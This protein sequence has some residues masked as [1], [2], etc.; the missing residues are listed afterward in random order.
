MTTYRGQLLAWMD[1]VVPYGSDERLSAQA[2][3]QLAA[4]LG[5]ILDQIDLYPPFGGRCVD[6]V[7]GARGLVDAITWSGMCGQWSR[8]MQFVISRIALQL[9]DVAPG[10]AEVG[11]SLA[12]QTATADETAADVVPDIGDILGATPWWLKLGAAAAIFGAFK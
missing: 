9:D 10:L 11:Y 3:A 12:G 4:D 6:R 7:T 8:N 1:D 2:R 5:Y